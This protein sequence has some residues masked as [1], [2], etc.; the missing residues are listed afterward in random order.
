MKKYLDYVQFVL[1]AVLCLSQV[2]CD[3]YLDVKSNF[4]QETPNTIES[5]RKLLDSSNEMNLN[6]PSYGEVSADDYFLQQAT[7][8]GLSAEAK[9]MY[10]WDNMVYYYNNDWA[11]GYIPVY[12]ANLVLDLL[13]KV[14]GSA[15]EKELLR[16][17][18]LFYRAFQF[19]AL[20]G[21]Y[22]KSYDPATASADLGIALRLTPDQTERSVR[23]SV[24]DTYTRIVGDLREATGLLPSVA[25]HPMRPSAAAAEALLARAYL[26]IGLYDSA[27]VFA[28]RCLSR[29]NDLLDFNDPAD[30]NL[31]AAFPFKQFNAET[32]FYAQLTSSQPNV[33]PSYAL[34]DTLV[35]AS[36]RDGDLRKQAYFKAKGKYVNFKGTYSASNNLFGGIAVDE[37]Y[38]IRAEA[39]VRIGNIKGGL[40]DINSLLK[41]R[42]QKDLYVPIASDSQLEVLTMVLEERRKELIMRGLRWMDIKRL[43]RELAN[44]TIERSINGQRY[45]L[46][47]ADKRYALP[48]PSDILQAS[49]MQQ[50]EY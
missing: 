12:Q 43:N 11:K 10:H 42:W 41:S 6:L 7:Y 23:A 24:H 38:L 14:G 29:K 2:S 8:D 9:R 28:D 20:V 32:I 49:G 21:I 37:V 50:N 39:G 22:G 33:H 27:Y 46:E 31:T 26:S 5:L 45:L 35:Y 34:I 30:V 15:Q 44:I 18:A 1:A 36:Y 47:P 3:G 48:L 16:G 19:L 40:A 25:D 17:R 4:G 13:G